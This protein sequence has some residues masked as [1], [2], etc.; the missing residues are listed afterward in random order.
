[1]GSTDVAPFP[2]FF[3]QPMNDQ[4]LGDD[5]FH[6]QAWIERGERVLKNN[7]QVATP[8][9][10]FAF[11]GREQVAAFQAYAAR[12]GLDQTKNESAQCTLAR[13]GFPNQP[14]RLARINIQRNVVDRANFAVRAAKQRFAMGKN[15]CQVTNF[16]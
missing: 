6:T 11:A 10:H 9:A 2:I 3:L 13:T 15:L 7:L 14:E 8:A 12:G 5:V 4:G 16:E 1:M